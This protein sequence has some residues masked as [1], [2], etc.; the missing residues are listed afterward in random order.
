MSTN[1]ER[2]ATF[3]LGYM[4]IVDHPQRGWQQLQSRPGIKIIIS[5]IKFWKFVKS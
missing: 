1:E 4:I 2:K 3:C 5:Y